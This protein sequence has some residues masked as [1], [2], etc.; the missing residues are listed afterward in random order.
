MT[1]AF[2][3]SGGGSLGVAQVG[4]V[5][6]EGLT[7]LDGGEADHAALRLLSQPDHTPGLSGEQSVN[8]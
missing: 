6:R 3:L 8:V 1:T 4:M 2:V 5:E 7:L